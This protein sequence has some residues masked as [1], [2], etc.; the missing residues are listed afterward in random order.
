MKK[1]AIL[2]CALLMLGAL[3]CANSQVTTTTTA[4]TTTAA[5]VTETTTV[6]ET[7]TT[8]TA[9]TTISEA[10]TAAAET[11]KWAEVLKEIYNTYGVDVKL[12]NLAEDVTLTRQTGY[13]QVDFTYQ[14]AAC[15]LLIAPDDDVFPPEGKFAQKKEYDWLGFDCE[16]EWNDDGPA[17]AEWDDDAA[18]VDFRLDVQGGLTPDEV[19]ELAIILTP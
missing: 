11:D 13:I 10:T 16:V 3:G 6:P 18:H 19:A 4:Q 5:S 1:I 8:T 14:K 7:T 2:L 17:M 15:T 12:P 9:A